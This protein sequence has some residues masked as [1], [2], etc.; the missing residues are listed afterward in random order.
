MTVAISKVDA[1][2][3]ISIL[4]NSP[5]APGRYSHFINVGTEDIIDAL[6]ENYFCGY[7]A[8]GIGCFKYLE[9]DYGSG[10]TQF[11]NSLAQRAASNDVVTALVTVG[12][13]CPFNSPAAIFRAI[14]Q[15]FQPPSP[16]DADTADAKGI[17]VLIDSWI[18]TRIRQHGAEPGSDVPDLV[19]RRIEDQLGGLWKGA[20]DTQMASALKELSKR[21]LKTNCG[22]TEAVADSEL[23]SWVRG[24]NVRS[25][26]LKAMG[27]FEPA[28]DD[29]AFRRLKTVI[30]FLRT[31][32]AYRGFL[33]A[34]DEG[35]RTSSFRRGSVKQKQAIEN[36]LTM[37]NQNAEGEFGGV[38]FLYAATP[39]FRSEVIS[40][41]RAL[42][43]RIGT[44]AFSRGSPQ[45]PL[46]NIEEANS[47][48]VIFQIGDRLL[49]VFAKAYDVEWDQS[50]QRANMKAIVEAQKDRLFETPKP[51]F[52]V[53]Q[54]CRFLN[55]QREAQRAISNE[56]ANDFVNDNEPPLEGEAA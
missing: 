48:D 24:D 10:K 22:A 55:G 52:F 4:L 39:D 32:M 29:N 15:S 35:T 11:I 28:R 16:A 53:Y 20:P 17:E 41:Y 13:E 27:L 45:V 8:D 36:L 6:G 26:G 9:G 7:L 33:I 12:T 25:T 2:R 50:L 23:I 40:T 1:R 42:Q 54:Y 14:M 38:M 49:T 47:E 18:S 56:Q 3:L 30:T 43:D 51:R 21:L 44:V 5:I 46:I 19:Q 31:R 34:F 37:I